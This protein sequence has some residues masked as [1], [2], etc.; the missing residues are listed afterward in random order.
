[1]LSTLPVVAAKC[2]VSIFK[3]VIDSRFPSNDWDW[4]IFLLH[5][6]TNVLPM[7]V[8]TNIP[9]NLL[10]TKMPAEM[11]KDWNIAVR[12]AL[13]VVLCGARFL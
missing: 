4:Q 3:P 13:V 1:M 10:E 12:A 2:F 8:G 11:T 9:P 7:Y 5:G 6:L